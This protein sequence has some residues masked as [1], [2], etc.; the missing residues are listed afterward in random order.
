MVSMTLGEL[1]TVTH[2]L[3]DDT[4]IEVYIPY[5]AVV[6]ESGKGRPESG[7]I[8]KSVSHISVGLIDGEVILT[9]DTATQKVFIKASKEN[10]Q[11][12][13]S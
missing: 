4:E 7:S 6:T 8:V 11:C 12:V 9:T 2:S 3:P 1:R 13:V 10:T 5:N